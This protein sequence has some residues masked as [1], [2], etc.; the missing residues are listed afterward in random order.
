MLCPRRFWPITLS[1]ALLC[2]FSRADP[3]CDALKDSQ[4]F[5]DR[6]FC[7]AGAASYHLGSFNL[8]CRE[9][10]PAYVILPSSALDVQAA[11]TLARRFN[12]TFSVQGGGHSY[13]C[14]SI[15]GN[16]V[17]L[18]MKLMKNF[19]L[20]N[21]GGE[22]FAE[23]GPGNRL[24]DMMQN[25]PA[26]YE[27]AVGTCPTVGVV[28]FHVHGGS[29]P[30]TTYLANETLAQLEVV[31][32][33]G[34]LLTLSN[35]SVHHDLWI[36]MRMAGSSFGVVTSLTIKF[37]P[38]PQKAS[39]LL[40]VTG[41][42]SDI[43]PKVLSTSF[44]NCTNSYN[45]WIGL[46]RFDQLIGGFWSLKIAMPSGGSTDQ[47]STVDAAANA[48]LTY[49]RAQGMDPDIGALNHLVDCLATSDIETNLTATRAPA[50]MATIS[51][52]GSNGRFYPMSSFRER[53]AVIHDFYK[54]H[55]S[56]CWLDIGPIKGPGERVFI[57]NTCYAS[58]SAK[59]LAEYMRTNSKLLEGGGSQR[60]YNL[61]INGT[62]AKE[63]WPNYDMLAALK[64]KWDPCD[65]FDIP[66]GIHPGSINT[67][68]C[69]R[70]LASHTSEFSGS[71]NS[72]VE[73]VS[74]AFVPALRGSMPRGEKSMPAPT[75]AV[76]TAQSR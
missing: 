15:K 31:T 23:M 55:M 71:H 40:P 12:R 48:T 69:S 25:I 76:R 13:V 26:E 32:A 24:L 51:D 20:Y 8:R 72:Q 33:N 1:T 74:R 49:L 44:V 7:E 66:D 37:R 65:F 45:I 54:S 10:W 30:R 43:F 39:G 56:S 47:H 9:L 28:G 53:A 16:S 61:P 63:Y 59:E 62:A 5:P 68:V 60:Y 35:T 52:M 21:Q 22:T 36:A 57:D 3:L 2:A 29:S 19:R 73:S 11:V 75:P 38:R 18:D 70:F 42:F 67:T 6:V 14:N 58:A 34:F 50:V 41:S 27:Y 46:F 4:Q 17:H 64:E